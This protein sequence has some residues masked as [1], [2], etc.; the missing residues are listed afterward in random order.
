MK[1]KNMGS[2]S[3]LMFSA[4]TM[5]FMATSATAQQDTI[6]YDAKWKTTVKD[7]ASYFRPPVK[8]EGKLFRVTDHYISGAVQMNGLSSKPDAD[9]WEG[10]VSWY[11]E[12]GS[13]LQEG[14]YTKNRLDGP[15]ISFLD[16]ERLKAQFKNG[17]M[18]SGKTNGRL[19]NGRSYMSEVRGDTIL[20]I[21]YDKDI[22]GARYE[23][24]SVGNDYDVLIQYFDVDGKLMGERKKMA[25]GSR[26]GIEVS[27]YKT[28]MRPMEIRYY[29]KGNQLGSS[30]FYCKD[31]VRELFSAEN[32]LSK[33]YFTP[34]GDVMGK[35]EYTYV[36]ERLKP[37]EGT[38]YTFFSSYTKYRAELVS[39][40][41]VY[42]NGKL[43][44]EETF[45]ENQQT[46]S[47]TTY[48]DGARLLQVSYDEDGQEVARMEY[49][50]WRPMNGTEIQGDRQVTYK[51]GILLEEIIHYPFSP[52]VFKK[53]S[54]ATEVFYTKDGGVMGTL[55]LVDED[56]YMK[57]KN[58]ERYQI[59]IDGDISSVEIFK[60]G[61]ITK[62]TS[63]R[64]RQ[65]GKDEKLAFKKEEYYGPDGFYREREV[66]FYS[67]GQK[68][69]EITYEGFKEK[70]GLFYNAEGALLGSYDYVK[71]NGDLYEFFADSDELRRMETLENGIQTRLKQYDYGPGALY[72]QILP[73]LIADV[74]MDC[75]AS[76]YN[77]DG[78]L[79]A[80]YTFK[81]REPWEGRFFDTKLRTRHVLKQGVRNGPYDKLGY[82]GNILEEGQF[83]DG[84]KEGLFKYYDRNGQL[85]KSEPYKNDRLE[86]TA[87]YYDAKGGVQA[88]MEFREGLPWNGTEVIRESYGRSE[89]MTTYENGSLVKEVEQ[90]GEK[91]KTV[92]R[93]LANGE[94]KGTTYYPDTEI[95]RLDYTAKNGLLDGALL[96]YDQEGKEQY[97]AVFENGKIKE[98]RVLLNADAI[99]GKPAYFIMERNG[100]AVTVTF[101][102][103]EDKEL[104][105]ATEHL[106]FGTAS[107]FLREMNIFLDNIRP[108]ALY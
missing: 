41:R 59:D 1:L 94:T 98:G 99:R 96:R 55:Q 38:E 49:D 63:Y 70:T 88:K 100:D 107:V 105:T 34:D 8:K 81:D 60:E 54:G 61:F 80:K 76:H 85:L 16:G 20:N 6:Y 65:V 83:L 56:G 12:D 43:Q 69:S 103:Q 10:K 93:Y 106:A 64:K 89:R 29:P 25:N 48:R 37:V 15:Y 73:T 53:K 45:Y 9:F 28:P 21:I 78:E 101:M 36:D 2:L 47:I 67:N 24:Y 13:L 23:R 3:K 91:G 86:G 90:D 7:S 40:K 4:V 5:V 33:T 31:Q 97:R 17:K 77:R 95:K 74:D 87:A 19:S 46:K 75:C 66:R 72:G 62:R 51:D 58:G 102:G 92:T 18:V 42:A 44:R 50:N 11:N 14:H 35:I 27:Y 68:Q 52:L 71:K 32:G 108:G 26:V 104:F 30:Y 57:P 79:I 84:K 82:N 39:G 22:K